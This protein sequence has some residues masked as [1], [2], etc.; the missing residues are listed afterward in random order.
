MRRHPRGCAC[1]VA[2]VLDEL[3]RIDRDL[4]RRRMLVLRA[5][6]P[7]I[8]DGGDEIDGGVALGH[9]R[10]ASMVWK[11]RLRHITPAGAG[12]ATHRSASLGPRQ[13][14]GF[15]PFEP[16]GI[17]ALER[18]FRALRAYRRPARRRTAGR[19]SLTA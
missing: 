11:D 1:R 7:H 15:R 12:A 9:D 19:G 4:G 17:L 14:G 18:V 13:N 10:D 8:G 16:E 6:A 3:K 2:S 5:R